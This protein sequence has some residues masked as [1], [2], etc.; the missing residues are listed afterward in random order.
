MK[1]DNIN[2]L[3]DK[4]W[5]SESS[6]EEEKFL[7]NHFTTTHNDDLETALFSYYKNQQSIAPQRTIG[8]SGSRHIRWSWSIITAAAASVCLILSAY[9]L[10]TGNPKLENEPTVYAEADIEGALEATKAALA[11]VSNSLNKGHEAIDI[12]MKNFNKT[13]ILN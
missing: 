5:S 4:Y 8:A 11:I 6:L 13:N 1:R 2:K 3:L 9:W 10:Y 7:K 12:S